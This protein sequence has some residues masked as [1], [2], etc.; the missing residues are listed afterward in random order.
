M[1]IWIW[2]LGP[3]SILECRNVVQATGP[4]SWVV[5]LGRYDE[6]LWLYGWTFG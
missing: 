6:H 2:I 3:G 1:Q 5:V 4:A